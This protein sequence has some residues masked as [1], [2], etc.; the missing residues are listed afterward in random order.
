[1]VPFVRSNF[2]VVK[3]LVSSTASRD[4]YLELVGEVSLRAELG[5]VVPW[6]GNLVSQL[7]C[8]PCIQRAL[9]IGPKCIGFSCGM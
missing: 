6:S 1:M 2:Y 5:A 8:L 7:L 4:E 9:Y 3:F